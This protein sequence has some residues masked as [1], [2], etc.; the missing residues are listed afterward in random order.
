MQSI[1]VTFKIVDPFFN[2]S[3]NLFHWFNKLWK[4][5]MWKI[6]SNIIHN[7]LCIYNNGWNSEFILKKKFYIY[8][9]LNL[10]LIY[11]LITG[12]NLELPPCRGT[13]NI[14]FVEALVASI[15]TLP[16]TTVL[17]YMYKLQMES[18]VLYY[19]P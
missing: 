8:F 11:Q 4:Y 12:K 3:N 19:C 14:Y 6:K 2:I 1:T 17:I 13:I 9:N 16:F 18:T 15:L 5:E 7:T 10:Y